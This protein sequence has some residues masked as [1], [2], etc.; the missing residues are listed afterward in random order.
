MVFGSKK[1]YDTNLMEQGYLSTILNGTTLI[2]DETNMQPGK[3]INNGVKNITA[4][5]TLIEE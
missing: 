4:I 2:V 3:I 1:N 5:A